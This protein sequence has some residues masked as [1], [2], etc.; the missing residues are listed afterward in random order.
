[1]TFEKQIQELSESIPGIKQ[2][3]LNEESTKNSLVLPFIKALGYNIFNPTEVMPEFTADVGV[4]KGEKV[5]YAICID[6][7][8]ALLFECKWCQSS[9]DDNCAAQLRR[10]FHVTE[11]R[12]GVLTNGIKYQFYSDLD[13][14]NIMDDKPFMELDMEAVDTSLLKEVRKLAKTDFELDK[15]LLTANDLKY[16]RQIRN[17][18]SEQFQNPSPEF[19]RF[20]T[21]QVYPKRILPGVM[22]KFTT[23][24]KKALNSFV[25]AQINQRL[26]SAL[27][28]EEHEPHDEDDSV[29]ETGDAVGI[30]TTDEE[31]EGYHIVRA[32]L[33]RKVPP[34]RIAKRDTKSYF[35]VLLDDNNR[36]PICRLRFN[37]RQ[38]YIGLFD[39]QKK[40]TKHPI[41]KITD[42]YAYAD[43][44]EQAVTFYQANE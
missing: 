24:T 11:A 26:Q 15:M 37:T 34:E 20:F 12:I 14:S 16:T 23:I 17:L 5:D 27:S 1:M 35:G 10:Y 6:G 28:A 32:I 31:I 42:I 3:I 39:D 18:I 13:E 38:K 41:E 36:K 33:S 44:L 21:S 40:E 7:K 29:E 19:V 43:Q 4:K 9:L 25:N 22:E 8:P 2:N 30:V